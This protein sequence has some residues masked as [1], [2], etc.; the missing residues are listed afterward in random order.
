MPLYLYLVKKNHCHI[1]GET[2]SESD[3]MKLN[4]KFDS[5]NLIVSAVKE[6]MLGIL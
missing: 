1:K 5:L 2:V 6:I 3:T 4:Y